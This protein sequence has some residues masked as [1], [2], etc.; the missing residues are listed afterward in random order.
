MKWTIVCWCAI[1]LK[2]LTAV[3]W[4]LLYGD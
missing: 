1:L 3:S 4:A 2:S